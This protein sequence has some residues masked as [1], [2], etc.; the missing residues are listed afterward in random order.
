MMALDI[1]TKLCWNSRSVSVFVEAREFCV[2]I[3][4]IAA[5][6]HAACR[7]GS[8]YAAAR[9]SR[10]LPSPARLVAACIRSFR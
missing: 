3:V 5:A 2:T 6:T 7:P 10:P 9:T 8:I 4:S 1:E